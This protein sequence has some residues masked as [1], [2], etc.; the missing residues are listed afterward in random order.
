M[1]LVFRVRHHINKLLFTLLGPADLDEHNDPKRKL[2]REWQQRFGDAVQSTN[3][4]APGVK[5]IA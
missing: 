4:A 3:Q 5:A 1:D 2:D